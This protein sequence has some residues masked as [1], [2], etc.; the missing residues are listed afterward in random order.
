MLDNDRKLMKFISILLPC[1]N[2][3]KYIE[4][5][6]K[7]VIDSD[8]PHD[9]MELFIIDGGS[10]DRTVDIVKKYVREFSFIKL[11]NNPKKIVPVAM[12]MAIKNST[13]EFIIRIDAHAKFDVDYFSKLIKWHSLLN[14]DNIGGIAKTEILSN[15][16]KA[17]AIKEILTH[18]FGVG[19][20]FFRIGTDRIREVDTVPFGCYPKYV[21]ERYGYYDERLV[22]NQDIELNKRIGRKGG[23]IYLVPNVFCTYFARETWHKLASN[24]FEN[25]FWNILTPFYT[26]NFFSISIRHLAPL[27]FI[28][29]LLMPLAVAPIWPIVALGSLAVLFIYL[30]FLTLISISLST[31]DGI[32]FFYLVP[33]FLVLHFSYGWGSI[34]GIFKATQLTIK[35]FYSH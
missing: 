35:S 24:S 25:G 12:N 8:Y 26:R 5:C 32:L 20:S 33:G 29:T 18:R 15:S 13:G 9:L 6:I 7:S 11:L 2:E 19:N 31:A 14:A 1:Y 34:C 3:E 16:H 21:F 4:Q 27:I 28:V 30:G 17:R 23:K 10:N 22:R